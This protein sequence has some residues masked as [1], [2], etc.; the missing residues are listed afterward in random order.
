VF[1]LFRGFVISV[2]R[3]WSEISDWRA[4]PGHGIAGGTRKR[5]QGSEARRA[6]PAGRPVPP[7]RGPVRA[8]WTP[9]ARREALLHGAAMMAVVLAVYVATVPRTVVLEDDGEF[10]TAVQL[11]GVPHPPGFPSF[12]LLSKPFTWIPAGS[13]AFRVHVATSFFGACCCAFVW[14]AARALLA[15]PWLA[16][17]VALALAFSDSFWS[18]ALIADVYSLNAAFFFLLLC[19]VL[20]YA[21]R[22]RTSLLGAG[23][24]VAGLGLSNHWPLFIVALP[25]LLPILWPARAEVV[26]DVLRRPHRSVLPLALGLL[27]YVWMVVRSR[28]HPELGFYGAM[29]DWR[30]IWFYVSRAG[31]VHVEADPASNYW[32]R[33]Q[34]AFFLLR[35]CVA[36]FTPLGAAFIAAGMAMQW[37]RW[38]RSI[39][40]GVT[41]TFAGIMTVLAV[42]VGFPYE[43]FTRAIFRPYPLIAYGVLALWLGVGLSEIARRAA[44]MSRRWA[45]PAWAI[46]AIA[47]LALTFQKGF[48]ANDRH[49][50]TYASD[51]SLT[52]LESLAENAVAFSYGDVEAFTFAYYHFV[53]GVR[54]D[55]RLLNFQGLGASVDGRLFDPRQVSRDDTMR[56]ATQYAKKSDRPVYFFGNAPFAMGDVDYGFY[57]LA[58]R[59]QDNES[60][61]ELTDPLLELFRRIASDTRQTDHWTIYHRYRVMTRFASTLTA[62]CSVGGEAERQ[63]YGNDLEQAS[64]EF[65]GLWAQAWFHYTQG[66]FDS[67]RL[68]ELVERAEAAADEDEV[69]SRKERALVSLIKGRLLKSLDRDDEAI[70]ALRR[71]V[72]LR[73]S[74]D[75]LAIEELRSMQGNP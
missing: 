32:D 60:K 29:S 30:E 63:R 65:A 69:V 52:L 2:L 4:K 57:N 11:L 73:P 18:Q 19:L 62:V 43:Y 13:I 71:S 34:F 31:Y 1:S 74:P 67:Q 38:D 3:A 66:G 53:E 75:N 20:A 22:P 68:L 25:G 6:A 23:A 72:E 48:A 28:S 40:L 36:Q 47:I 21:R 12:V 54:P 14:W 55:I 17:V 9:P 61:L 8:S 51:Y 56:Y 59:T 33:I 70:A 24:F 39:A 58:D 5:T 7:A 16:W 41:T 15:S 45:T 50:Y 10:I 27:P 35:Q 42:K 46:P 49:A 44:A 26:R 64:I 37:R